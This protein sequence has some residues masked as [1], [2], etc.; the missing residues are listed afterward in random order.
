MKFK[1][2]TP[3]H[4]TFSVRGYPFEYFIGITPQIMTDRNH[5]A[6][7]KADARTSSKVIEFKK[8]HEFEKHAAFK[9]YK[10]IVGHSRREL[11]VQMHFDKMQII[12]LEISKGSEM[13]HQQNSHNLTV[14]K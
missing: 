13:K 1:S 11:G 14:A 5:R 8:E 12:M 7:H 3:S 10:A 4:G 9:L 2:V 6:V